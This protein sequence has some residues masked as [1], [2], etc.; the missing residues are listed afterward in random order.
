MKGKPMVAKPLLC[1]VLL[2]G[3][4]SEAHALCRDDLKD[5]RPAIDHMKYSDPQRYAW[6][7][8]W[9]G[10]AQEAEPG[11]ETECLNFL[12]QARK[13]LHDPIA[14]VVSCQGPNAYLPNCQTV[15]QGGFAP[16]GP[17]Q[18]LEVGGIAGG[19]GAPGGAGTPAFTPP[20]SP[21]Q[22]GPTEATGTDRTN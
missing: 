6:A 20:G 22:P 21:T 9:W 3:F 11:S 5:L 13:A 17:A 7:I 18:A 15:L 12:A 4:S 8:S 1:A 10:K 14:A 2:L 19:G 16:V